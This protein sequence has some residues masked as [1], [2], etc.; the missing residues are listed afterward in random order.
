MSNDIKATEE[1][2]EQKLEEVEQK[3]ENEI[4]QEV[5]EASQNLEESEIELSKTIKSK[6]GHQELISRVEMSKEKAKQI[7]DNYA[8]IDKE[9]EDKISDLIRQENNIV[10]TTVA[11]S[12]EL[13]KELN[14]PNLEDEVA[15]IDEIKIENKEQELKVKYPSKGTFK[16]LVFGA[17]A[18]A[19]GAVG[20]FFIGEKLANI[21]FNIKDILQKSSWDTV[22]SKYAELINLKQMPISGY[23]A[24]AVASLIL[25]FIVYKIVTWL[26][27]LSN[28]KYV[29]SLEK[30][31][32]EYAQNI[33]EKTHKT[34]DLIEHVDNIKLVMQKYDIILQEQNAKLKRMLFIEQPESVESL[35]KASQLEVEKSVLI[36]DELLK[37]MNTPVNDDIEIREESK[38][39]L[40]NAN[41]VINE[42]IKK[43]YI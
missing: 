6:S 17:L 19:A 22:A 3:V 40:Q 33:E 38:E 2:I 18:T 27:K 9:L 15:A 16:G 14:V 39:R 10:K 23:V 41:S 36:L 32:D 1:K 8:K 30:N 42:V 34:K 43:L 5:Q 35:Q 4:S 20:A 29:N 13:L 28:V 21:P 25:G 24:V 11:N 7:Y 26:Q 12:L 31:L 37:L